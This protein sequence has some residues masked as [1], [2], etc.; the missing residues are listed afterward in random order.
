MKNKIKKIFC[1][2]ICTAM[3]FVSVIP[4]NGLEIGEN[5]IYISDFEEAENSLGD[6]NADGKITPEDARICLR[7]A[8]T[9]DKLT[10]E[11]K[12][13]ADVFGTGDVN[14]SCAR[15]ILRVAAK[16]ENMNIVVKLNIGQKL[17]VGPVRAQ[18]IYYWQVKTDSNDLIMQ[19]TVENNFPPDYIGPYD[20]YYTMYSDITAVYNVNFVLSVPWTGEILRSHNIIVVVK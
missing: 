8:A 12:E 2:A 10:D 7:A 20:V 16:L 6:I 3:L 18:G 14:A 9:L 19:K 4:V 13:A 5:D 1:A 17:I 11:Q 15:K